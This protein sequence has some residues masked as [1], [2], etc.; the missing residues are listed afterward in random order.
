MPEENKQP[1]TEPEQNEEKQPEPQKEVKEEEEKNSLFGKKVPKEKLQKALDELDKAKADRDHWKNEFYRS[2][3]D[4]QNL[5]KA[6]ED[7]KRVAVRYRAEGFLEKLL[8]A[9]DAFRLALQASPE[10]PEAKNYQIG[11]QYN[12][13]QLLQALVDAGVTECAPKL[14]EPYDMT[15]M[16]A[17]D[18]EVHDDLPENTVIKVYS[19][20]YKLHDRLIRP[21]MVGVSRKEEKK[22]E[23]KPAEEADKAAQA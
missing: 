7:E 23:E 11:F 19:A 20:G 10:N 13:K 16:H 6:L 9:L 17:V 12:Y 18:A 1:G 5:R 22:A 4:M 3:A 2:Y 21:A 14:N 15:Y 8:P